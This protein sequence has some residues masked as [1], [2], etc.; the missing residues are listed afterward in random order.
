MKRALASP[1]IAA[2][3]VL[4]MVA[5]GIK[6]APKPPLAPSAPATETPPPPSDT[7][8]TTV[9]PTGPSVSPTTDGGVVTPTTTTDAD[10][11]VP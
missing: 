2:L 1:S 9:A 6:G 11:G 5:C 8:P 4:G 10:A 3:L 7:A